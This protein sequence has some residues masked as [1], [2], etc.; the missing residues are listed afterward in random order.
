MKLVAD[1]FHVHDGIGRL[2]FDG[3]RE[4]GFVKVRVKR[5]ALFRLD[6]VE[7]IPVEHLVQLFARHHDT[8][9][10]RRQLWLR[11]IAQFFLRY[12][13]DSLV[14]SVS[15]LEEFFAETLNSEELC[16]VCLLPESVAN[17]LSLRQR[18]LV[19]VL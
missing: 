12:T 8:A 11:R 7:S 16:V 3:M 15:Y 14:Q 6:F 18:S 13:F 5:I 19:F 9:M 4:Q 2:A 10:Q 1:I 17:V